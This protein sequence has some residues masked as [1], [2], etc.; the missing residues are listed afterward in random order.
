MEKTIMQTVA[1][2]TRVLEAER[3]A[4]SSCLVP[5]VLSSSSCLLLML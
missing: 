1:V 2:M 4:S 3:E 5:M